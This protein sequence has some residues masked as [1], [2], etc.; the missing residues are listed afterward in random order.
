MKGLKM[1]MMKIKARVSLVAMVG[2]LLPV[3]PTQAQEISPEP[4][5]EQIVRSCFDFMAG[6]TNFS[7][8]CMRLVDTDRRVGKSYIVYASLPGRLQVFHDAY[9]DPHIWDYANGNV[10]VFLPASGERRQHPAEAE[11]FPFAMKDQTDPVE[12]GLHNCPFLADLVSG[13]MADLVLSNATN[14]IDLTTRSSG[15]NGFP[16]RRIRVEQRDQTAYELLIQADDT[17]F[18]HIIQQT[19]ARTNIQSDHA[20]EEKILFEEM[21][22]KWQRNSP[23]IQAHLVKPV[24]PEPVALAE[25]DA[26]IQKQMIEAAEGYQPLPIPAQTESCYQDRLRSR[27]NGLYRDPV[28]AHAAPDMPYREKLEQLLNAYVSHLSTG[29]PDQKELL[30]RTTDMIGKVPDVPVVAYCHARMLYANSIRPM[31]VGIPQQVRLEVFRLLE[32][33]RA[34]FQSPE[35]SHPYL[36]MRCAFWRGA[37]GM[38][39]DPEWTARAWEDFRLL[40]EDSAMVENY[41]TLLLSDWEDFIGAYNSPLAKQRLEKMQEF[42]SLEES[43]PWLYHMLMGIGYLAEGWDR[44]EYLRAQDMNIQQAIVHLAKAYEL[45]PSRPEAAAHMIT[46]LLASGADGRAMRQW[47]DR[48]VQV[49]MDH[50]PAYDRYMVRLSPMWGGNADAWYAFGV[51]CVE[52]RRF[53]T[54]VPGYYLDAIEAVAKRDAKSYDTYRRPGCYEHLMDLMDGW[55][56]RADDTRGE[57]YW[58]SRK[59]AYAWACG[60]YPEAAE[61]LARL[62]KDFDASVLIPLG[63]GMPQFLE[64]V[65]TLS[66]PRAAEYEKARAVLA[67]GDALAARETIE[68]VLAVLPESD[69]AR[70]YFQRML[71]RIDA[72]EAWGRGEWISLMSPELIPWTSTAGGWTYDGQR[73]VL[74]SA[75]GMEEK[76]LCGF[77]LGGDYEV[78]G[79]LEFVE[80]ELDARN[81]HPPREFFLHVGIPLD[82]RTPHAGVRILLRNWPAYAEISPCGRTGADR[83]GVED[84]NVDA[85]ST[86]QLIQR[87]GKLSFRLNGETIAEGYDL[88][89]QEPD[90]L[91]PSSIGLHIYKAGPQ[92]VVVHSLRAKRLLD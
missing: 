22:R 48:T 73:W 11:M 17:P 54:L 77:A 60:H 55:K 66:N 33:A 21:Y 76:L 39:S 47:F 84:V 74:L 63:A 29:V 14:I 50:L 88:Q 87:D 62:G 26:D 79:T 45:D 49:E 12:R 92:G 71:E 75:G 24:G 3:A 58:E 64:E 52:T 86:F 40:L 37:I 27:F 53:D 91:R 44:D 7:V 56:N 89:M 5:P 13:T 72:M 25:E 36:A 81:H 8:D 34:G 4:D 28:L 38:K 59:A 70:T 42:K 18:P 1:R 78:E 68:G 6:L 32:A 41:D 61:I 69:P 67:A 90:R 65:W 35:W 19:T 43:R 83:L 85:R 2:L 57:A 31:V 10:T 9:F 82:G 80:G 30:V 16:C 51:E 20:V 15:L 23:E 46:A